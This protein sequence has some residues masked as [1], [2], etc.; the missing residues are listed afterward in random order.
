[1]VTTILVVVGAVLVPVTLFAIYELNGRY[2]SEANMQAVSDAW[3]NLAHDSRTRNLT[4]SPQPGCDDDDPIPSIFQEITVASDTTAQASLEA[5]RAALEDL[6]WIEHAGYP[7]GLAPMDSDGS[8]LASL[9][10]TRTRPD[11]SA[12]TLMWSISGRDGTRY[13]LEMTGDRV[14]H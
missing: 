13:E 5:D 14:G 10:A 11:R 9:C 6:G 7:G 4:S 2:C 12:L 8:T 3:L 1:M